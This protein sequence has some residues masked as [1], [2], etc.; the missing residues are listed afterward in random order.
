VKFIKRWGFIFER[1]EQEYYWWHAV[2]VG[3]KLLLAL[4]ASAV[5]SDPYLQSALSCI[6]LSVNIILNLA[7][8]P[9]REEQHGTLDSLLMLLTMLAYSFTMM[10]PTDIIELSNRDSSRESGIVCAQLIIIGLFIS[11]SLHHINADL[12]QTEHDLPTWYLP[13]TSAPLP[14][15]SNP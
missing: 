5:F 6:V 9:F 8:R 12:K 14:P 13:E 4:I 7:L 2:V 1:Y 11:V 3:R 10:N 15:T